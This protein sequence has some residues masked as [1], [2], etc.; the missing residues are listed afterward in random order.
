VAES[1]FQLNS[2]KIN[3]IIH[4]N[5]FVKARTEGF[6]VA[7]K[8]F[9][10]QILPNN[11]EIARFGFTATKKLGGAVIRNRAKRRLRALVQEFLIRNLFPAGRDYIFI[12]RNSIIDRKFEDLRGDLEYSLRKAEKF[13]ATPKD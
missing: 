6:S 1:V 2:L 12:A 10:I 3:T 9:I 13:Y 5:V 8:G 11:L 4:R 7:P